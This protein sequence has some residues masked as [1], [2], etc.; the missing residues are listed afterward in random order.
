M[1]LRATLPAL[2]GTKAPHRDARSDRRHAAAAARARGLLQ[3]ASPAL[4]RP[5]SAESGCEPK[6]ETIPQVAHRATRGF[7]PVAWPLWMRA[8]RDLARF[9]PIL[10]DES[11][12]RRRGPQMFPEDVAKPRWRAAD[13]TRSAGPVTITAARICFRPSA[14]RSNWVNTPSAAEEG[15][16]GRESAQLPR[17]IPQSRRSTTTTIKKVGMAIRFLMPLGAGG[18]GESG[19]SFC[20]GL[21]I[22]LEHHRT[23]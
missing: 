22:L 18:V 20:A 13:A 23:E 8:G 14:P 10:P 1:G 16:L 12:N 19:T 5:A 6:R 15:F 9:V 17:M 2:E 4:A 7:R 21:A 11:C 3:R